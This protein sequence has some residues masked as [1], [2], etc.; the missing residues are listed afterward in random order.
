M[1][2]NTNEKGVVLVRTE[3]LDQLLL[4]AGRVII[5]ASNQKIAHNNLLDLFHQK[6]SIN[7]NLV[8]Q[9]QDL[10]TSSESLSSDLHTLVQS[11]R[12]V[13]LK[14]I[15]FR[16]SRLVRNISRKD[17]KQIKF[18]MIGEE[19]S[20]DKVIS[21]KIFDPIS[22]QLR[23]AVSHGIEDPVTRKEQGKPPEGTITLRASNTEQETFIEIQDDGAGM[24]LEKI[25]QKGID[26]G[27]ITSNQEFNNEVALNLICTPSFSTADTISNL[28]GRGVGMDVV[29]NQIEDLKGSVSFTT[30]LGVGTTFLF[31]IP[32]V[33]AVNIVDALV[34]SAGEFT[35]AF[36]I[37]NVV[38]T[39]SIPKS[40]VDTT[41]GKGRMIRH[42]DETL[43]LHDLG[44]VMGLED[45]IDDIPEEDTVNVLVIRHKQTTCAF[46][47][48]HFFSPQKLV[49]VPF[50]G[51]MNIHGLAGSTMLGGKRIGY[52]IDIPEIITLALDINNAIAAQDPNKI[53]LQDLSKE[54]QQ[55]VIKEKEPDPI[56]STEVKGKPKHIPIETTSFAEDNDATEE[57]IVEI[58]KLIPSLNDAV[59]QLEKTP[60]DKD[61]LNLAFRLF[62][63]IKGNF[64]LM[65]LPK[66][67]E[68]IHCVESILDSIRN[69]E[70]EASHDMVD[71]LMDGISFIEQVTINSKNGTFEDEAND[72]I[73]KNSE[74]LAPPKT[75]KQIDEFDIE[76]S[77]ITLSHETDYIASYLRRNNVQFYQCYIE[78]E[79]QNQPLFLVSC[80]IYRRLG[81]VS[82]VLGSL[83]SLDDLE[84]GVEINSIK[85]LFAT[86]RDIDQLKE[87][88]EELLREHYGVTSLKITPVVY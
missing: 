62:H 32:L 69:E 47:I 81:E 23:N 64:L 18:E 36:P 53:T 76:S 61:N 34:V 78:L 58:E 14:E 11:I 2:D 82:T 29:R 48:D 33:S 83:P 88:L 55:K 66:A 19:T 1:A 35:F 22:H 84:S 52:I 87:G 51:G 8:D 45:T 46:K 74:E 9:M 3:E 37:S 28:S 75:H 85:L 56:E 54:P 4:L 21:E 20:V 40:S 30:E 79:N 60:D 50:E 42:L 39:L 25:K 49:I 86:D 77:E 57:L 6:K 15:G 71:I 72:E 12:T 26:G 41:L 16:A 68:T 17:G 24:D 13:N 44:W 80:L 31:R 67:C 10:S 73:I 7:S 5:T 63:T 65:G 27:F 70:Q 43:S 38:T 59:F